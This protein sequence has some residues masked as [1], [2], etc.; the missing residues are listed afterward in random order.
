MVDDKEKGV[1][2]KASSRGENKNERA[3]EK[4]LWNLE[5]AKSNLTHMPDP[6]WESVTVA[7]N[8]GIDP[9]SAQIEELLTW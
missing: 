9:M 4:G 7:T 6:S 5:K 8:Q 2:E 3:M 1:V